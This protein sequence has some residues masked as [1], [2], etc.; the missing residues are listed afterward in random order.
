MYILI[1]MHNYHAAQGTGR[2]AQG[3][4]STLKFKISNLPL[5]PAP[6]ALRLVL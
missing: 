1:D 6:C 2:K 5:R 3:K 4:I